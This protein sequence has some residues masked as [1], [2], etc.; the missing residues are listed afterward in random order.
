MDPLGLAGALIREGYPIGLGRS[1]ISLREELMR[2]IILTCAVF[3]LVLGMPVSLAAEESLG[4][5]ARRLRSEREKSAQK[6]VKVFTNDELPARPP[7]EGP[8]AASGMAPE[9]GAAPNAPAEATKQPPAA[10]SEDKKKTKDYWQARFRSVRADLASAQEKQQLA[11][12]ELNLLQIQQARE[13]NTTAKADLDAKVK[14]KQAEVDGSRAATDKAKK[15]LADLD[16]EF[17]DSGAPAD[18]S[19]TD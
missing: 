10:S 13:L 9:A 16:K 5:V 14:A 6:P 1:S 3:A 19:K 18:W 15:D 2:K 4:D 12:D 8:S 17:Q 11:E 7:A